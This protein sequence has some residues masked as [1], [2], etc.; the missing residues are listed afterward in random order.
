MSKNA[1]L[2]GALENLKRAIGGDGELKALLNAI[3]AAD[4]DKAVVRSSVCTV[5]E[6]WVEAVERG[7]SFIENAIKEERR[8]IRTDGDVLPVEKIKRVSKESVQHLARHSDLVRGWK[9]GDEVVPDKLLTVERLNDYATYENRF[10]YMLLRML[11]EFVENKYSQILKASVYHGEY[12]SRKSVRVGGRRLELDIRISDENAGDELLN[13][14]IL[15]RVDQLRQSI[16]F[17]LRTPLMV[18][19]SKSDVIHS[20]LTKTNILKMDRNFKGAVELYDFLLAYK[21]DGFTSESS[22]REIELGGSAGCDSAIPAILSSFITYE[23]GMG[24]EKTFKENYEN[25]ERCRLD[26]QRA[27]IQIGVDEKGAENYMIM[28]QNRN[29]QL[30]EAARQLVS[31]REEIA[32]LNAHLAS[33]NEECAGLKLQ[34]V[35]LNALNDDIKHTAENAQ[36]TAEEA[37]EQLLKE[38]AEKEL[39]KAR[40]TAARERC[41]LID[42]EDFISEEQF[43]ALERDYET[44]G[45]LV[46]KKW[47][48]VKKELRSKF[49][50][51]LKSRLFVKKQRR[52]GKANE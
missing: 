31:A 35:D 5:D 48:G 1:A 20:G 45:R 36:K 47:K 14:N 25:I 13:G 24:L 34:I 46:C 22:E 17:C 9:S 39:I 44:L 15:G 50:T 2:Y 51:D 3:A 38:R 23:Q 11:K 8:F 32:R 37:S 12:T 30:E 26:E 27:A 19:V 21:G 4:G 41:G 29:A 52:K 40:L 18:E 10:L 49:Y 43:N 42:D 16:A 6:K 28:L 33:L 7:I